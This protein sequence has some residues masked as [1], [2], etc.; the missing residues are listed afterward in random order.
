[1]S[2]LGAVDSVDELD[3]T[4]VKHWIAHDCTRAQNHCRTITPARVVIL[5]EDL[6][7]AQDV[8]FIRDTCEMFSQTNRTC[9]IL[10]INLTLWSTRK[11]ALYR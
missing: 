10:P 8:Q 4:R 11:R 3:V 6:M 9:Q 2:Q 5:A 1:M 7:L